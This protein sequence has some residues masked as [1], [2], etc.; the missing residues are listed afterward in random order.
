[1]VDLTEGPIG[2]KPHA[3]PLH[4]TAEGLTTTGR[5][6][7]AQQSVDEPRMSVSLVDLKAGE[8]GERDFDRPTQEARRR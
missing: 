2:I 4:H 1:M 5:A 8:V 3:R 6:G 7:V